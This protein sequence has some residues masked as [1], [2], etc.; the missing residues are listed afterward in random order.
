[1]RIEVARGPVPAG[2]VPKV[3]QTAYVVARPYKL[4]ALARVLDVEAPP[5]ALV[6]CL[7]T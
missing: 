2:E 6:F 3:R 7:A 5:A 1:M 4:A